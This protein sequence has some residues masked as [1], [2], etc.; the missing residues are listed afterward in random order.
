VW[1][2]RKAFYSKT[3][4]ICKELETLKETIY[5]QELRLR[6]A[7]ALMVGGADEL[8]AHEFSSQ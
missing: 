3:K 4:A 2:I 8:T 5:A 7:E 6:D 1:V